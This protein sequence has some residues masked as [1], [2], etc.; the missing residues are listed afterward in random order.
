[1]ASL[2]SITIHWLLN[3]DSRLVS[4]IRTEFATELKTKRICEMVKPIAQNIDDL[5]LRYENK[6]QINLVSAK[7]TSKTML[8]DF[9]E[10]KSP[11]FQ[12]LITRIET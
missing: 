8:Q 2:N 5:L 4:I 7:S 11:A 6:E 3:I 1:M 9:D 12:A 10:E